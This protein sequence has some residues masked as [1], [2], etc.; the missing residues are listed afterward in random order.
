M[1][2]DW[3]GLTRGVGGGG[4]LIMGDEYLTIQNNIFNLMRAIVEVAVLLF[5][6][7]LLFCWLFWTAMQTSKNSILHQL[8][9]AFSEMCQY[10][11][12]SSLEC[13]PIILVLYLS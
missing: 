12:K 4:Q 3:A 5:F 13:F 2:G 10:S 9:I 1:I 6:L 11:S 8:R 7:F